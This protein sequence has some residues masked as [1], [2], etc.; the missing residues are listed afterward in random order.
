LCPVGIPGMMAHSMGKYAGFLFD[1]DNT[2]FDYDRAEAEA[3][4]E[5]LA[6]AAPSVPREAARAEYRR[7]NAGWWKLFEQGS[8]T[9]AALKVGRFADLLRATRV[10]GDAASV[11]DGYLSRLSEKAYFLPGAREL[12]EELARTAPL[13]IVTNGISVVQRGRLERSG[14][15]HCFSAFLISEELGYAKPDGRF[16]AAACAAMRLA[17]SRLLC[18]GD[19]PVTD[20]RGAM[21]AGLD[22]C[23]YAPRGEPWPGPGVPPTFTVRRLDEI[24]M[25]AAGTA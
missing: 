22:A 6:E 24:A 3:L 10:D 16:F 15:A 14:I 12:V 13:G 20:V 1:A 19:N 18:V 25:L 2:L 9:L 17:P 4:D 11:S 8:V 21:A 23:W 5:T 7:I